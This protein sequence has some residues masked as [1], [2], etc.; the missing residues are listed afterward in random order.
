MITDVTDKQL[1]SLLRQNSRTPIAE[2]AR[3]LSLS[4]STVKDR[5]E[6]LEKNGIIKGYTV[7]LSDEFTKGHVSAHVMVNLESGQSSSTIRQLKKIPQIIKAY[8]VSGIYD[9]II[10]L[11]AESTGELDLV[12]DSLRELDGIKDTLTS[13]VLSVKFER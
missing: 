10:V 8:A 13:V 5:I 11:D 6:R 7:A 3:A 1:L 2:L 4:R 9:L 12:L